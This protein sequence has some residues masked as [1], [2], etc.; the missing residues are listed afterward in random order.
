MSDKDE[1]HR[2]LEYT[3]CLHSDIGA[4]LSTLEDSQRDTIAKVEEK[5]T[6]FWRLNTN[7][8]R[9]PDINRTEQYPS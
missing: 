2:V 4:R 7:L 9:L 1:F 3:S 8:A 5:A 6:A